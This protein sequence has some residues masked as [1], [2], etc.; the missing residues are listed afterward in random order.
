MGDTGTGLRERESERKEGEEGYDNV[1]KGTDSVRRSLIVYF[2]RVN[3][4]CE[5]INRSC[6]YMQEPTGDASM[7]A[8]S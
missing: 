8:P 4:E 3:T 6:T 2:H 5:C 7:T 1:H